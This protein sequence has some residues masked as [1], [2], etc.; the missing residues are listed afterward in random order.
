M[1]T[2]GYGDIFPVNP[3]EKIM[4]IMITVFSCGVYA[5]ALNRIGFLV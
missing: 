2:V 4:V 1:L 3:I 5:Y